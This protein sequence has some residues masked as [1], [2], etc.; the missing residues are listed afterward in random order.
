MVE[1][2]FLN[3][4]FRHCSLMLAN[5]DMFGY[6]SQIQLTCAGGNRS[7]YTVNR[8]CIVGA[9]NNRVD[10]PLNVYFSKAGNGLISNTIHS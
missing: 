8:G 2:F 9:R 10:S 6:I 5:Q 7:V 4:V 1:C 3:D